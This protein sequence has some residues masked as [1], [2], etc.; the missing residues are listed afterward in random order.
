MASS[1]HLILLVLCLAAASA[2]AHNITA[3]L[4]GRS[5]YTLYNSYLSETKV[6]D[7]INSR[8]TVTVLVLTN[9][10]MSS[11]VA[12]LSLADI[13]N[14]LRLLTLLDYF[15][16]KKLHSLDSG[17]ELTTSLYQTTGQAAGNMGH[18]NITDLRG[19]KVA[20]ASAAPGAKF[21]AT[22][23]QRVA[24]FPSNLSVLEVTGPITFPGLFGA[25][26]A[27]SANITDLLDKAGCKQFARLVV[28]SG[29]LKMY[30]AAMDKALTL[31]APNDDA[32]KAKDLP[33]L[34]KLT[35]A[36]LVTLLQYHALPQYLPKASLKVAT[37]RIPTLA[38]T[39]AG[40]YDLSVVSRGDD[41]SLDSGV[42]KS[43]VASTVLDDTPTVIHTVDSVLLPP[44]LFGGAP[45]PAPAA[46]APASA[47]APESPPAPAPAPKAAGKKKK[48]AKSPSH[49]P[50]APPADSPDMSPADAPAD[51][52][53]DKADSKKN[54]AAAAAGVRFAATAA[55][56]A[57]AVAALL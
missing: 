31:L 2:S 35:S 29:V 22:Y 19:G 24:E 7:E 36:D 13:K 18:V 48:K 15:D 9:G 53:A 54:G 52:A 16:E 42:D 17:S 50:P 14:A 41:V 27:S 55:C 1:H 26:A 20:F 57:V 38:S 11:L 4:D 44:E 8:S 10:A 56:V 28:S 47:P 34:A 5:D 32:F 49:S 45:S 33:D 43:R 30:E 46:D 6:C 25:P 3:I 23:A 21:Q 40:K 51:D 37:G 12:N 39:G